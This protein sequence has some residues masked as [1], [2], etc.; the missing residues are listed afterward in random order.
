MIECTNISKQ[1]APSKEM[2][3][4]DIKKFIFAI[5][6]NEMNGTA[7]TEGINNL[8]RTSYLSKEDDIIKIF[9]KLEFLI[10]EQ[11]TYADAIAFL[12]WVASWGRN[13]KTFCNEKKETKGKKDAEK[14]V[15]DGGEFKSIVRVGSSFSSDNQ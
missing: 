12:P 10:K 7:R 9:N 1:I 3:N 14:M 5:F 15:I 11:K 13:P 2:I 4:M 8:R 6:K